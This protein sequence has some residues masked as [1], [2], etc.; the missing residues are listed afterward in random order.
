MSTKPQG[1]ETTVS[2]RS[3]R[4]GTS[5]PDPSSPGTVFL[6]KEKAKGKAA[7][8]DHDNQVTFMKLFVIVD[9]VAAPTAF[10]M[11]DWKP[12]ISCRNPIHSK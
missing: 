11:S 5:T 10:D 9:G 12:P 4:L 8:R 7:A 6:L 1:D 2:G 3:T